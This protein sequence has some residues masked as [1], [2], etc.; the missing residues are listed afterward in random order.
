MNNTAILSLEIMLIVWVIGNKKFFSRKSSILFTFILSAIFVTSFFF[1][2][3]LFFL[4]FTFIYFLEIIFIY[5]KSQKLLLSAIFILTQNTLL[6]LTWTLGNDIPN[7]I[8]NGAYNTSHFIVQLSLLAIIVTVLTLIASKTEILK[9]LNQV[10]KQYL[11]TS[12]LVIISNCSV[13]I[14]RQYMASIASLTNYFYLTVI[15]VLYSVASLLVLFLINKNS[16]DKLFIELLSKQSMIDSEQQLLAKEF[17]HDYKAFLSGIRGYLDN[18][19]ITGAKNYINSLEASSS[20]LLKESY[21]H[22]IK[23]I[24]YSAIQGILAQ[25]I[26]TCEI[27]NLEL[28]LN[29]QSFPSNVNMELIDFLRCLSILINNAIEHSSKKV[30]ISLIGIDNGLK[31]TVRNTCETTYTISDF[32]IKNHSTKKNHY[33]IGLNIFSKIVNQ[34]KNVNYKANQENNWISFELTII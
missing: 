28:T 9:S 17:K 7:F 34:Y 12:F 26:S 14:I 29:I 33:G 24:P 22:Q 11:L 2:T 16:Q 32:F 23:T 4:P 15:L 31:I 30:Y 1:E 18:N 6:S 13:L 20:T 3:Y 25:S 27:N 5:Q 10:H 8:N 21:F 19:D